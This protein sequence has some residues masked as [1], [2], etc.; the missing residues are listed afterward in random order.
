MAARLLA[1]C[2]V[3]LNVVSPRPAP[4]FSAFMDAPS[5]DDLRQEIDAIDRELHGL[6]GRRADLVGRITAAKPTGGL[7]IRPGREARVLR[8]RLAVHQGAFPAAA[9]FRMW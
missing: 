6:I 9:V 4:G 1:L 3:A 8:Q 2:A 5:L 7:A